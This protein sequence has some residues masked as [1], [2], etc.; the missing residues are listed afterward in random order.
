LTPASSA[1]LST[2]FKD[3]VHDSW[4]QEVALDGVNIDFTIEWQFSSSKTLA[5]RFEDAYRYGEA[6]TWTVVDGA[7]TQVISGIWRYSNASGTI[8]S[9][10]DSSGTRFSNDDGIWGAGTLVDGNSSCTGV[11]WGVGNCN[12]SDSGQRLWRNG[13]QHSIPGTFKNFMYIGDLCYAVDAIDDQF[14]VINDGTSTDLLVLSNDDCTGD[15]PISVVRLPGD[16]VPDRGG[17][18]ITDGTVVIYTP[19]AGFVGFEDWME[20]TIR[21]A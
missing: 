4:I 21:P 9:R 13:T 11:S 14:D 18:A 15:D 17:V 20:A 7:T 3:V 2:D 16:L 12:A 5:Q 8:V 6:V 10:F 1:R 19:A